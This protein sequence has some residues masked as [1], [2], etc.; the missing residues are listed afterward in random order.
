MSDIETQKLYSLLH[1]FEPA[2]IN[3]A[4]QTAQGLGLEE[5]TAYWAKVEKAI[6][7]LQEEDWQIDANDEYLQSMLASGKLSCMRSTCPAELQAIGALFTQLEIKDSNEPE[8]SINPQFPTELKRWLSAMPHLQAFGLDRAFGYS[9]SAIVP[10]LPKLEK[11]AL[12]S[13]YGLSI[14]R[15]EG[16]VALREMHLNCS[17]I[18]VL[19][20]CPNI[21][22]LLLAY[23]KNS[24]FPAF[25]SLF[26]NLEELVINNCIEYKGFANNLLPMKNL[27]ALGVNNNHSL[28][29]L[30]PLPHLFP[31]L[32][33]L[34]L[35]NCRAINDF[36]PLYAMKQLK[37]LSLVDTLHEGKFFSSDIFNSVLSRLQQALPNTEIDC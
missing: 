36:T 26:P 15:V 20:P 28:Y 6:K 25:L 27:R 35:V 8:G 34:Y 4:L 13:D 32:Q 14:D 37:K 11:I 7:L 10:P 5:I 3:I 18:E 23:H 12:Q 22:A 30:S 24:V 9:L 2:N 17:R 33:E 21:R 16:L 1:T 19:C 29:N 31:N